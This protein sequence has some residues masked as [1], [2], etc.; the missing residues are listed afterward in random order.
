MLPVVVVDA[1]VEGADD[2]AGASV[3]SPDFF[4]S[5]S[6]HVGAFF[7]RIAERLRAIRDRSERSV[8]SR[9]NILTSSN[10]AFPAFLRVGKFWAIFDSN[11]SDER[12]CMYSLL[13]SPFVTIFL[14]LVFH[15]C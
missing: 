1:V 3:E 11:T 9:S 6:I 4:P 10:I 12:M 2:V 8:S 7:L 13:L 14:S 15:S 5:S